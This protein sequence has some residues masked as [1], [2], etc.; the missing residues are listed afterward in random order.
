MRG[1]QWQVLYLLQ[2]LAQRGITSCLMA[3]AGSPLLVAAQSAGYDTQTLRWGALARRA[4]QFDALH[5]HDSH[6][7][8]LALV[9]PRPLVVSRRVAFP[10]KRT[11]WSWLKYTRP[12]QFLAVSQYV[13]NVLLQARVPDSKLTVVYDGV[14]LPGMCLPVPVTASGRVIALDSG[15][16]GKGQ[17][18][19]EQASQ[20]AGIPVHFSRDLQRDLRDA[21]LFVYITDLEGLGSAALLA[22]SHGVPVLAS[23]TG[24][25]PEIV[26]PGVTGLLTNNDPAAIAERMRLLLEDRGLALRLGRNGRAAVERRFTVAHMVEDTIRAYE[27]VLA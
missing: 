11:P 1:G 10:I 27:Q 18:I 20:L 21:A 9:S 16:P 5:A 26:E 8:T 19:V 2:G 24:G 14:Y 12:V 6:A 4:R 7:H 13:K 15:D 22:M 3:P 23:R 17:A 25:L